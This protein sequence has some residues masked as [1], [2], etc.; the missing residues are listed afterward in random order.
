MGHKNFEKNATRFGKGLRLLTIPLVCAG[1]AAC[2]T[3][4]PA[5]KK[6]VR[7][8]EFFA[9]SEYG[10]KA[11]P[12]V[13]E[14]GQSVPKG[15]GR[16]Q[17]GKAY[18][19]RGKWYQPKEEP[20][21]NRTG[22]A[23]WYGSAFHGRR[24]ANGEVYDKY[25]LSAAHPTFPLPSYARVTNMENGTS[26]VVRVND[27]GPFHEGR[28]ID[29]SSKTAD[30]LD[31]KRTGTAKVRVQYVGKA[32]LEG[33]DMPYL[34]ASYVTKGSRVPAVDPGGQIA[35]GVMVA[36]ADNS[37]LPGVG[38]GEGV[39]TV[40]AE[41]TMTALAKTTPAS[42]A[43]QAMEQFVML[44]E[45][46]PLPIER[47]NVVPQLSADPSYAAAYADERVRDAAG[48]FDAILTIDGRLTPLSALAGNAG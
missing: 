27:R 34:M 9:E 39:L 28:V 8:K 15:G 4:T 18:Q 45:I 1:L 43:F 46:G 14:E 29:V 3:T 47:P 22:L 38:Q 16:Y 21:Y 30:L 26:V 31:M 48:A 42:E 6:K 11:S 40:P 37:A 23:S 10:V 33:N 17:V 20:G 7:S 41:S 44:P 25:H 35:T 12:R 32:P 13:V 24:T 2:A 19:V 5:P 36:S